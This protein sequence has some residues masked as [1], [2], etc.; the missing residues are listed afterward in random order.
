MLMF[1]WDFVVDSLSRFWR[2]NLIKICVRTCD[3]NSTLGFVVPL[4]MFMTYDI[5]SLCFCAS[6]EIIRFVQLHRDETVAVL[7]I[8]LK[9]LTWLWVFKKKFQNKNKKSWK[10][11]FEWNFEDQSPF[12]NLVIW[13]DLNLIESDFRRCWNSVWQRLFWAMSSFVRLHE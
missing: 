8:Y 12:S 13:I 7:R 11:N 2:W 6:L 4:A 1:G 9:F 3:M 10:S 5:Q